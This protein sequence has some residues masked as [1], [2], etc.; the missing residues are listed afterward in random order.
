MISLNETILNIQSLKL[1]LDK[2]NDSR[3]KWFSKRK[4]NKKI[5]E[6]REYI[7]S[8]STISFI[9]A[10]N[11]FREITQIVDNYN[12]SDELTK[13]NDKTIKLSLHGIM[14]TILIKSDNIIIN[15]KFIN[16]NTLYYSTN[17]DIYNYISNVVDVNLKDSGYVDTHIPLDIIVLDLVGKILYAYISTIIEIEIKSDT[18]VF[19][20]ITLTHPTNDINY[21]PDIN[22]NEDLTDEENSNE[23][24]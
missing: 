2:I 9:D 8:L 7:S 18:I 20:N 22:I 12:D 10:I 14:P 19:N 24:L 13:Y 21:Q 4:I 15:I 1:E 5:K 17:N 16:N 3:F 11:I 23:I 6:I